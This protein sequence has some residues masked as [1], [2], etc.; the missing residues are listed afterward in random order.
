MADDEI[1]IQLRRG[2]VTE[3][4]DINPTLAAGEPGFDTSNGILKIGNGQTPWNLL[5]GISGG[6]S[7]AVQEIANT[8]SIT[9]TQNNWLPSVEA[10]ALR[11]TPSSTLIITG[12]STNYSKPSFRLVNEGPGNIILGHTNSASEANNQL[13]NVNH[14]NMTIYKGDSAS[15]I[16]DISIN[17]WLITGS[18]QA[19]KLVTLTQAEYNAQSS[20]DPNTLYIVTG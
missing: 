9:G 4:S 11:M 5:N 12:V 17:K 2:T 6:G 1:R 7:A 10:Y 13:Y 19:T 18:G 20:Y 14:T 8:L 16:Y 15:F 3:W